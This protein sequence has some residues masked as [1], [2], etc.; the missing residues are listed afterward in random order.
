M[1]TCPRCHDFLGPNHRC[2][3]LWRLRARSIGASLL[4]MAIG[5]VVCLV[6]LYAFTDPP[7]AELVM[8]AV[9]SGM[10]LGQA[11]WTASRH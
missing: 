6:T 5:M 1:A 10:V 2:K 3:G 11:V 4:A 7:S 8:L 9:L